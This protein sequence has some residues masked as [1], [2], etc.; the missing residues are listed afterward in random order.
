MHVTVAKCSNSV[1]Q[2]HP[3]EYT[4]FENKVNSLRA[5]VRARLMLITEHV[6]NST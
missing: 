4:F 6:N 1:W 2:V 3:Q 5:S